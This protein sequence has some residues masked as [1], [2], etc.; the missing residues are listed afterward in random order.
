LYDASTRDVVKA[1]S[2][3]ALN[4]KLYAKLLTC[5]EGTALQSIVAR[6]HLHSD[7]LQVLQDLTATHHPLHFPEIIAAKPVQFWG[8]TRRM[9]N[10]TVDA[11]YNRFKEL[12]DEIQDADG[13]I[14]IKNAMRHFIFMLGSE[15]EPIQHNY[16]ID[17]LPSKWQTENWPELLVL[18]RNYF[19][20]VKPNG[21]QK[22]DNY[23]T[24]GNTDSLTHQK[25][26]R[27][28]FL[29]P[30][31]FCQEIAAAQKR[32]PDKCIYHLSPSHTTADCHIK[33]ECDKIIADQK[34]K[35]TSQN[36][37]NPNASSTGHLRNIKEDDFEDACAEIT[38][39]VDPES[40][41][42]N[43]DVLNYF[44]RMT[45][46]Y[47]RLVRSTPSLN[48]IHRHQMKFPVI[49]DSGAN[50]HMFKEQEFFTSLQPAQGQVV[51]GDGKT[52]LSIHGIG[53]IRC[54]IADQIIT[55]DD[56]RYVPDLWESIYSLFRHIQTPSH[57]VY[58]S[59]EDG[60]FINFPNL[61]YKA[62][63]GEHDIYIDMVPMS[64]QAPTASNN[65]VDT[66]TV[67]TDSFCRNLKQFMDDVT[68][69]TKYLDNVLKC[70]CRY[71]KAVKTRRQLGMEVPAGFRTDNQWCRQ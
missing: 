54:K 70:L 43:Q 61:Q 28:W 50:M 14:P 18:C 41:D 35:T 2:N 69:E 52:C 59:F 47:L 71:Y 46:H 56:V 23:S 57:S 49:A 55:I 1:T 33:K 15:F 12:L 13:S 51:L 32:D 16:H 21:G 53:S 45:N 20:S 7:G 11:Y 5:L 44:S 66:N 22:K 67:H 37:Y 36:G 19:L 40:N 62:L 10:E 39:D 27:E 38:S 42:T 58:S 24:H 8:S 17:N 9:S 34:S 63:L 60:L 65:D 68:R 6:S 48:V 29:H 3:T 25:K 64:E 30:A 4:Q 26:V 31:K